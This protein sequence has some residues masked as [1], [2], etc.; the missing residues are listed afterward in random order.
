MQRSAICGFFVSLFLMTVGVIS[1][2]TKGMMLENAQGTLSQ[3]EVVMPEIYRSLEG[4]ICIDAFL[5]FYC[6]IAMIAVCKPNSSVLLV[7]QVML[8][9]ILVGRFVLGVTFLAGN[10]NWCRERVKDYD[11][12]SDNQRGALD[13]DTRLFYVTLK[14]AWIYEIIAIISSDILGTIL[15]GV[16]V[17]SGKPKA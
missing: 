11:D 15:F 8:V 3:A 10:D 16:M 4:L 17:S 9:L 7:L 14:A 12:M 5:V 6:F 2:A 1:F 13:T